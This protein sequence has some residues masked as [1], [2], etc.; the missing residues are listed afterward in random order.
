M[1]LKRGRFQNPSP[2][3]M[4][5]TFLGIKEQEYPQNRL[6]LTISVCPTVNKVSCAVFIVHV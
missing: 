3:L 1:M 4:A 6:A 5:L 2:S